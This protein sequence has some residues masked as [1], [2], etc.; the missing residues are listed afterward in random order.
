MDNE[1]LTNWKLKGYC[2]VNIFS[3]EEVDEMNR[4]LEELRIRRNE[5]DTSWDEF[6]IYLHPHKDSELIL[7][8]F[9]NPKIIEIL[10]LILGDEVEGIQSQSYYKPPGELGRDQHQ[11]EFYTESGWG[12]SI[13]VILCLDNSN[14]S[15]GCLWSYECSHFLP[16]LPISIDDDR[17]KTNTNFWSNERGKGCVMPEKHNFIKVYH[18]CKAGDVLFVHNHIVHGSNKNSSDKY[19]RSIVMS[20]KTKGSNLREGKRMKREPF[21]VYKLR[22]QY[23]NI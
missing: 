22:K 5:K 14:K 10:E 8:N 18:E 21:D 6:D 4:V 17:V 2:S 20:Y 12:K 11:D 7:K 15:N 23:W 16:I 9:G 19:R 1:L 3:Q 13:N